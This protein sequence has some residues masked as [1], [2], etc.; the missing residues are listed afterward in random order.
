MATSPL[1]MASRHDLEDVFIAMQ[2]CFKD[3]EFEDNFK[4]REQAILKLRRI[5]AGN[6]P[7]EF[8]DAFATGIKALVEGIIKTIVSLVSHYLA[9][10]IALDANVATEDYCLQKWM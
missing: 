10:S 7:N 6:A 3:K 2:P 4:L 5:T 9:V 1:Y 8:S